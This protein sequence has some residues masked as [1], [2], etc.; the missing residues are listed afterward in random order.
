MQTV[1]KLI[2]LGV[3]HLWSEC[4][5]VTDQ[6]R[7]LAPVIRVH[8]CF[9]S[10]TGCLLSAFAIYGVKSGMALWGPPTCINMSLFLNFRRFRVLLS[11]IR[12]EPDALCKH[13][14]PRLL[15]I[16]GN[17]SLWMKTAHMCVNIFYPILSSNIRNTA[18]VINGRKDHCQWSHGLPLF[19]HRMYWLAG[20]SRK[21]YLK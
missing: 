19:H 13:F 8:G 15:D 7:S 11:T 17:L 18:C 10:W 9:Q 12:L 5:V 1:L 6:T 20:Q 21:V 4:M 14:R 3:W 2:K 16:L